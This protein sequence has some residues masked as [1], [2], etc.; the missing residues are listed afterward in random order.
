LV[1]FATSPERTVATGSHSRLTLEGCRLGTPYCNQ[2]AQKWG[3]IPTPA[4]W[5]GVALPTPT[6]LYRTAFDCDGAAL[7]T[8]VGLSALQGLLLLC[9]RSLRPP[10]LDP[11]IIYNGT[12]EQMPHGNEYSRQI[13]ARYY[14]NRGLVQIE[15]KDLI[16]LGSAAE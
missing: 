4:R 2:T 11:F 5:A 6:S 3:I 1:R 9:P 15:N 14:A 7:A 13:A 8:R 10:W 12:I 16:V